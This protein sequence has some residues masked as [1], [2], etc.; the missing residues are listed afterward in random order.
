MNAFIEE[1]TLFGGGLD[2]GSKAVSPLDVRRA[3]MDLLARR[4]HSTKELADKLYRRFPDRDVIADQI[5]VLKEDNLQSDERFVESFVN[6]R[7][8]RGKGPLVI[9]QDLKQRGISADLIAVYLDEA[10][11]LWLPIAE[12]TYHKKFGDKPIADQKDKAR[13]IRFMQYRGFSGDTIRK[14][15]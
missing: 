2:E 8:S 10:P 15:F 14:L 13:R 11:E 4:E 9:R 3:A 5:T 7:K 6:G 1:N 12:Q